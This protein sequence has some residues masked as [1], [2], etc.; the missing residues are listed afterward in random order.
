MFR[1]IIFNFF[2]FQFDKIMAKMYEYVIIGITIPG[3]VLNPIATLLQHYRKEMKLTQKILVEMLSEYDRE[4][5]ALN[6]VT[7]SRW[8]N[9]MTTP[10]LQKKKKILHF[11][12][13]HHCLRSDECRK[14]IKSC[15]NNLYDSLQ[16]IFTDNYQY[17]IGNLPEQKKEEYRFH[18]LNQEDS[19]KTYVEHVVDIEKAS[20]AQGYYTVSHQ[21]LEQWCRYPSSFAMICERKQQH[22]G[23]FVML[24]IKNSVA[25]DIAHHRRS[26]LSL[27]EEDFCSIREKGSYYVHA[28]YGCNP[29]IAALL[30]VEAYLYLFEH[31]DTIDNVMIFSSRTDGLLLTKDYGI[32]EVAKGKD[33]VYGFEWHGM[34]SPVE[35][36]LFSDTVLKLVF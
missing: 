14:I 24:K 22:L 10:S 26:E 29:K 35:E 21:K 30:N 25:E 17:I 7:L 11:L 1:F 31:I 6:V 34:L 13:S 32:Q 16:K 19:Y 36:I 15:Y 33:T 5:R 20:N 23:H 28:L 8:E 27:Q 18:V 4:F 12:L 3:E 9:S 2:P